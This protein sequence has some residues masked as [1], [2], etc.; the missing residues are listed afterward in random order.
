MALMRPAHR[1]LLLLLR[2]YEQIRAAG[3][4]QG[5]PAL[6]HWGA[7]DAQLVRLTAHVTAADSPVLADCCPI[8]LAS[9]VAGDNLLS[10]QVGA[11]LCHA[12]A[13]LC[14]AVPCAVTAMVRQ[15]SK[16]ARHDIR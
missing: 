2:R 12:C 8:C 6:C 9:F 16:A 10:V 4:E 5:L 13:W 14:T 3:A 7:T 15:W 11:L 1:Q